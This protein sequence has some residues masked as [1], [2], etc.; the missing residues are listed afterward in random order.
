MK[1]HLFIFLLT[2]LF[3]LNL[4][5]QPTDSLM[6]QRAK[7]YEKYIKLSTLDKEIHAKEY[8]AMVDVLKQIIVVDT[9]VI[10][11]YAQCATKMKKLEAENNSLNAENNDLS[12]KVSS[13]M[14]IM[15]VIYI[16]SGIL[17]FICILLIIAL[18]NRKRKV[19]SAKENLNEQL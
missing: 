11:S 1:K 10:D 18:I 8:K 16:A 14:S 13:I 17:A 3:S 5:A 7:L 9:R 4:F 2:T 15:L 12:R 19:L 6:L